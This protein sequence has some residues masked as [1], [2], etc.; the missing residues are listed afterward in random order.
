M[1]AYDTPLWHHHAFCNEHRQTYFYPQ[2]IRAGILTVGDFLEDD[3]LLQ[4]LAPSWRRIYSSTI[5]QLAQLWRSTFI[6]IE[7]VRLFISGIESL[8]QG[9]LQHPS[10]TIQPPPPPR[11]LEGPVRWCALRA[12]RTNRAVAPH[13]G[14][15][16]GRSQ[17][18]EVLST[19]RDLSTC[20]QCPRPWE[21]GAQ[22][23]RRRHLCL[24]A[25]KE[26][27]SPPQS[28]PAHTCPRAYAVVGR[29]GSL[30][31]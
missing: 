13:P 22:L 2:L 23:V 26:R 25:V 30:S 9:T 24:H 7:Q 21:C 6:S 3:S 5:R 17:G 11:P 15:F 8:Q 1:L 31:L 10:L 16:P 18:G 12:P 27:G 28:C 14:T 20:H 29:A 4:R 19:P